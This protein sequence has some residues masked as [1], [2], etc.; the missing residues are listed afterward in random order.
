MREMIVAAEQQYDL[1]VIDTPPLSAVSD[2]IP[3]ISQVGGVIV[4]GRLGKTSRDAAAR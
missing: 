2:A 1:M 3:L 4:V